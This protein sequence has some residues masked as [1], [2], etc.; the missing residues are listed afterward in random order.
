MKGYFRK[1]P[2]KN[3]KGYTWSFTVDIGRDP[4]TGK[5]RQKTRSGFETKKQAQ[6]AC[7]KLISELS[8]GTYIEPSKIAYKDFLDQWLESKETRVRKATYSK[9][10]N[11]IKNHI[12]PGLGNM[13][14]SE[15]TP[16]MIDRFYTRLRKEK[17]LSNTSIAD[18]HNIV[19]STFKQ[20]MVWNMVGR[21]PAE[22]VTPPKRDKK[23]PRL[24]RMEKC[25]RFLK[26]A[27]GHREYIA[28]LLALTTGMRQ[29]EIL[30]LRWK[31]IDFD[32]QT[33]S[34]NQ[35]LEH[36]GKGLNTKTKSHNS[37]RLIS[38]DDETINQLKKH[39]GLISREKLLLGP[40]YQDHGLVIPTSVGTPL[41]PRNLLRTFYRFIKLSGVPKITFHDLRHTHASLL[42]MQKENPKAVAERL[43]HDVRML[44]ETYAHILPNMQKETA[45]NF[46]KMFY[47]KDIQSG[48]NVVKSQS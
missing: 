28:F 41:N 2:A 12:K 46:G 24:R 48:K 27:Q 45:A 18:I 36:D 37:Y 7:A 16:M 25:T 3:R 20:A 33:I 17:G 22:L 31:D 15:I 5:R 44:M 4:A 9:Y 19:K 32:R 42:L 13:P 23:E 1:I 47:Q 34:V 11:H 29:S 8:K 39:K 10:M 30:A 35:T 6:E 21:N 43:G 26:A 38:I 40:G 14:L